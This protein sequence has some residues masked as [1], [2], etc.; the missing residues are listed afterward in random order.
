MAFASN[1]L[2][3]TSAKKDGA[4][5]ERETGL[6]K[7]QIFVVAHFHLT[8]CDGPKCVHQPGVVE[9]G[10]GACAC[11]QRRSDAAPSGHPVPSDRLG[12]RTCSPV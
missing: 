8:A 4:G 3:V 12:V 6:G 11:R 9:D 1:G 2:G 5:F 7:G 10:V